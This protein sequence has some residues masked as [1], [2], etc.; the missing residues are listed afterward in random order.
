[1]SKIKVATYA[2]GDHDSCELLTLS[3][4]C[5]IVSVNGIML[6]V[7]PS[8]P[9]GRLISQTRL[10]PAGFLSTQNTL[11]TPSSKQITYVIVASDDAWK[12]DGQDHVSKLTTLL[13]HVR[14]CH[15]R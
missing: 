5:A 7:S 1:M 3:L 13:Y 8:R 4:Q 6:H 9:A 11:L 10:T 14:H 15:K 2:C 12:R